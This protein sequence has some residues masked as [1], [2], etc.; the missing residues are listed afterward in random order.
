MT[1]RETQRP[2]DGTSPTALEQRL[3]RAAEDGGA[4]AW[5]VAALKQA[6]P[7]LPPEAVAF[8]ADFPR[9]VVLGYRLQDAVLDPIVDRPTPLYF[10]HYR[11]VNNQL[12]RLALVQADLLQSSGYRA[13]A[14]PA[15][16]VIDRQ[17]MRGH[18]SHR[19]LGWAAGLGFIGRSTLLVHP[20]W[21]ARLR[22]VTILTDAPLP[23]GAPLVNACGDCHACAEACPAQAI[24]ERSQ[25]YDVAACTAKLTEFTHLPFIGQHICGVCVKTCGG[26]PHDPGRA[27][28]RTAREAARPPFRAK[29][30]LN[31]EG[32]RPREPCEGPS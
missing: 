12:D 19:V 24:R 10:H 32:E 28:S 6:L 22:Y 21:G 17:P 2:T 27:A 16:Q 13:L 9:A 20:R 5:G 23:E 7:Y 26:G 11:Q 31:R 29:N 18:L 30:E 3:R 4:A 25:D 15:S 8:A 1:A 14:V